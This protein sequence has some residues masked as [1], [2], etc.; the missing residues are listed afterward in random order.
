MWLSFVKSSVRSW[1][2]LFG[3]CIC[4]ALVVMVSMV[5]F[6]L[7][8]CTLFGTWMGA[9]GRV[10]DANGEED[11]EEMLG[12]GLLLLA[13][14]NGDDVW[15]NA[16]LA[17]NGEADAV[18]DSEWLKWWR[19]GRAQQENEEM[20]RRVWRELDEMDMEEFSDA[21]DFYG[22]LLWNV[23][24]LGDEFVEGWD[25]VIDEL[26]DLEIYGVDWE[27]WDEEPWG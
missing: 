6:Y 17:V 8:C 27:E 11:L 20:W 1:Y 12:D 24:E 5:E 26:G 16:V 7:F 13:D 4:L 23:E 14:E 3:G 2:S 19:I 18:E 25:V 9:V 21:M 22:E 15:D 10:I